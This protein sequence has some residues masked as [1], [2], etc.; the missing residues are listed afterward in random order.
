VPSASI[1]PRRGERI[2]T[3]FGDNATPTPTGREFTRRFPHKSKL[4]MR[5]LRSRGLAR[6]PQFL[7]GYARSETSKCGRPSNRLAM[8]TEMGGRNLVL[9]RFPG[10]RCGRSCRTSFVAPAAERRRHQIEHVGFVPG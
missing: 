10:H 3:L 2:E 8:V 5:R 1:D 7:G 4:L 9:V 6:R